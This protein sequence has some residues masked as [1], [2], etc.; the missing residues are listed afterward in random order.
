M[1]PLRTEDKTT[2]GIAST[3]FHYY[4]YADGVVPST[5]FT[6]KMAKGRFKFAQ[7]IIIVKKLHWK[8]REKNIL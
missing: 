3:I 1:L 2:A 4:S 8:P 5:H 6:K 7:N